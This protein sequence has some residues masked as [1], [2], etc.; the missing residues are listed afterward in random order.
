[1]FKRNNELYEVGDILIVCWTDSTGKNREVRGRLVTVKT[2]LKKDLKSET[3]FSISE[4]KK[5]H[6]DRFNF[7]L[8]NELHIEKV[9]S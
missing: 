9:D 4:Y 1:M 7:K 3:S 6:T 8:K 5:G 2:E